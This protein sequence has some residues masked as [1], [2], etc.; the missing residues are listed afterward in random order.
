MTVGNLWGIYGF[1]F[2]MKI[3]KTRWKVENRWGAF[4]RYEKHSA[5][6]RTCI[7]KKTFIL[8]EIVEEDMK[9]KE[10]DCVDRKA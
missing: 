9:Q 4:R 7:V 10:E 5:F 8:E 6:F 3:L 2:K 1:R